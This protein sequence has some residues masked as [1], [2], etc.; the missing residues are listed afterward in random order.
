MILLPQ[1]SIV[2]KKIRLAKKISANP[3]FSPIF[4]SFSA[5]FNSTL[6]SYCNISPFCRIVKKKGANLC[7]L[8][9][10]APCSAF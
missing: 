4:Y 10:F 5:I 6:S 8:H 3:S 1:Q 2:N 9:K 7:N